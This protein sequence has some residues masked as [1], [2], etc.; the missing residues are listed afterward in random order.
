M[1]NLFLIIILNLLV[2]HIPAQEIFYIE[3]RDSSGNLT[4][5]SL[6]EELGDWYV[7][8]S[9]S[10]SK[11][12]APGLAGNVLQGTGSRFSTNS[13]INASYLVKIS[14]HEKFTADYAYNI[15]ITTPDAPS[16]DAAK[17]IYIL[18]D[19]THPEEAPLSSGILDLT[20]ISC[21]DKWYKIAENIE[22]GKGAVLKISEAAPQQDR[23]YADAVMIQPYTGEKDFS[24]GRRVNLNDPSR[25]IPW[26]SSLTFPSD[27]AS[28]QSIGKTLEFAIPQTGKEMNWRQSIRPVWLD[29]HHYMTIKYSASGFSQEPNFRLVKLCPS[30]NSWFS[31]LISENIIVDG[32]THTKTI[33]LRSRTSAVQIIGVEICLRTSQSD[34]ASL[35]IEDFYFSDNIPGFQYATPDDPLPASVGF[36]L[37]LSATDSWE[38][39]PDWLSPTNTSI[40]YSIQSTGTSLIFSVNDGKKGMKWFN[41]SMGSSDTESFPFI[42]IKYRCK[43]LQNSLSNYAIWL[44]GD[45]EES[46]PFYLADLMDDGLWHY[47]FSPVGI[48]SVIQM[49]FQI[50]SDSSGKAFLEIADLS[51]MD[52]DPRS[53]LSFYTNLDTGWDNLTSGTEIFKFID[54]KKKFNSSI[55]QVLPRMQIQ[56]P[57]FNTEKISSDNRIPFKISTD[58]LNL[59]STVI[60]ETSFI[61]IPV[62]EKVKEIYLL[63]GAYFPARE[64]DQNENIINAVDE[65]ER[66][67]IDIFYSDKSCERFFPARI[68]S[69]LHRIPNNTFSALAFPADPNK[70]INE[71][72]IHDLSDGGLFSLAAI[73][74]NV[75]GDPFY[76]EAFKIPDPL[77]INPADI[78]PYQAPV[79]SFTSPTLIMKNRFFMIQFNLSEGFSI[80]EYTSLF[81][82][83]KILNERTKLFSGTINDFY[84]TSLSFA[85]S[86]LNI[87]S[88]DSTTTAVIDVSM[89][90]YEENIQGTLNITIDESPEINFS[91]KLKNNGNSPYP[92]ELIFP[93]ISGITLGNISDNLYYAYPEQTFITGNREIN[94]STPY[95]GL[96]PMQFMDLF[97]PEKGWGI[98][99]LVK[100]LKLIR[101]NFHLMKNGNSASFS[102]KYPT[103]PGVGFP[104]NE[105]LEIA[106]F[107]LALHTGDWH[108]ALNAY[109]K[110]A[111]TW[112]KPRS[113]RQNWFRDIYSCRR[114]YPSIGTWYLY[115]KIL[116]KYTMQKE[117]DNAKRYLGGADMIDISSWGA[118]S[119]YG[120]VGEYLLYEQG[121]LENFRS[122]IAIAQDQD[123]PVGLYI[124]GYLLDDRCTIYGEHG[125]EW[126]MI[127][128][129]G[130]VIK[131]GDH[132][133]FICPFASDWQ[134]FMKDLY[135]TVYSDTNTSAIYIDVYGR[136]T[137][138]CF[139][140]EHGHDAGETTLR[141]EYQMTKKIREG[142]NDQRPGI[143]LYTEYTPVDYISQFQDGSFS[144]TIR[145]GD[146][147]ITPTMTNLFRFGFPDFKQI[148]L[149]NGLFLARNWT[150]EGLKKAFLN[151]EG[152]WIKGDIPSWYDENT[153]KF[154]IKSHEIFRDHRDAFRSDSPE[155]LI[156]TKIGSIYAN[157][158]SHN[159][160]TIFTFYNGNWKSVN[161]ELINTGPQK[162]MHIVDL[163]EEEMLDTVNS[164]ENYPINTKLN[165]RDIGCVGIFKRKMDAKLNKGKITLNILNPEEN[166]S[167]E[168][169]GVYKDKRVSQKLVCK[170]SQIIDLHNIFNQMPEKVLIK[171]KNNNI[172]KDEIII[173]DLPQ[174][175]ST[176]WMLF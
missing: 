101:K 53:D 140:D 52:G 43:N 130:E 20:Y 28:I 45:G 100:D 147:E 38:A 10:K 105:E 66:L 60:E 78:P 98:Y 131:S 122:E 34:N 87:I 59:I 89:K 137:F 90:G 176:Q 58:T 132:E 167:I 62:G 54:L 156:Q 152:I 61:S 9:S 71:I 11:A 73:T 49:A 84:F 103:L 125:D 83:H 57:W 102:I 154:Y 133:I 112:Y 142:L 27:E 12:Q 163:W 114:D 32:N 92:F 48:S 106:P 153:I 75:S 1:K 81:T 76:D 41:S 145:G 144:Y 141:G 70:I 157:K 14:S 111:S 136:G 23:F 46:R 158:F 88:E 72:N 44:N 39:K 7:P 22:L 107:S 30:A 160:K 47:A 80:E 13:T 40:D 31:A 36:E 4:D 17:S 123:T 65:T 21:G 174:N 16:I 168:L 55:N 159:E 175:A 64:N 117:L 143:P 82:D 150:E 51:F 119:T 109:Q 127:D 85:P 19:E 69:G 99:L 155:A 162:N 173:T 149:V 68:S 166:D 172:V 171:L 124:E 63:L 37:D 96:F 134:D 169:T 56:V 138:T 135:S 50:Q 15:Y 165:P 2:I 115:D 24:I 110:W 170:A 126:N 25:W 67:F 148:E 29:T 26:T 33:D 74:L 164:S 6:Y 121:G 8:G 93:D 118:S 129:N 3:S 116:D 94:I 79:V 35:I 18:Y 113:P 120:R 97:N 91:M 104:A 151:G 128:K 161:G 146:P 77:V 95:S 86:S 42:F 139:S 5:A 108:Q